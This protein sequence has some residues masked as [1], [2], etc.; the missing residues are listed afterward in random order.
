MDEY[1]YRYG[2][3]P[4][5]SIFGVWGIPRCFDFSFR[6]VFY[7]SQYVKVIETLIDMGAELDAKDSVGCNA[8]HYISQ[9]SLTHV[10]EVFMRK[11][12]EAKNNNPEIIW[13]PDWVVL[14]KNEKGEVSFLTNA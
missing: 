4:L 14:S 6:P 3:T 2:H 5:L 11:L 7:Q 1:W 12:H 9:W 8:L 10:G 13:N